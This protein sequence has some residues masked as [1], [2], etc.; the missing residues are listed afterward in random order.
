MFHTNGTGTQRQGKIQILLS[1]DYISSSTLHGECLCI[2]YKNKGFLL[3]FK[4]I[5]SDSNLVK[6]DFQKML[7]NSEIMKMSLI[8]HKL[9]IHGFKILFNIICRRCPLIR[10]KYAR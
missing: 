5:Y 6:Q 10:K 7:R 8:C 9:K 3:L 2:V 1:S 4:F